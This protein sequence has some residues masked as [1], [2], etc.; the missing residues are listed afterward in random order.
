M[1]IKLCVSTRGS[2]LKQSL[3]KKCFSKIFLDL[4]GTTSLVLDRSAV[5]AS[6]SSIAGE[7]PALVRAVRDG[8]WVV[9]LP[10]PHAAV[11]STRDGGVDSS[12]NPSLHPAWKR[13]LPLEGR[14]RVWRELSCLVLSRSQRATPS[15]SSSS[16]TLPTFVTDEVIINQLSTGN[17]DAPAILLD[18]G[19]VRREPVLGGNGGFDIVQISGCAQDGNVDGC[20]V[21][22]GAQN[23]YLVQTVGSLEQPLEHPDR[24]AGT[25]SGGPLLLNPSWLSRLE[26]IRSHPHASLQNVCGVLIER[27]RSRIEVQLL[28]EWPVAGAGAVAEE[29]PSQNSTTHRTTHHKNPSASA[30][31]GIPVTKERDTVSLF[32]LLHGGLCSTAS[33]VLFSTNSNA[34]LDI[35]HAVASGV[36]HV[37]Q[38]GMA[39]GAVCSLNV[40]VEFDFS[41][42]NRFLEA[43]VEEGAVSR[44]GVVRQAEARQSGKRQ[45][46]DRGSAFCQREMGEDGG[47][48]IFTN[49]FLSRGWWDGVGVGW[50]WGGPDRAVLSSPSPSAGEGARRGLLVAVC[51]GWRT[52]RY[53]DFS[54]PNRFL[55]AVVE[56]GEQGVVRG[57]RQRQVC[58]S[59]SFPRVILILGGYFFRGCMCPENGRTSLHGSPTFFRLNYK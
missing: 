40:L 2:D 38:L 39:H 37:H 47:R 12:G 6:S 43:V 33:Q 30:P 9:S 45:V 54:E 11:A 59:V 18:P 16:I 53:H 26:R 44:Q 36:R 46:G 31:P 34:L 49:S 58:V 21:Q 28:H 52:A 42:L 57:K 17:L 8:V 56:K 35:L 25:A 41:D 27:C 15:H 13:F 23:L 3:C 55:D 22:D 50:R 48:R 14:E 29:D 4:C 10:P 20:V 51:W 24:A 5:Q 1:K 7:H 19:D 32:E